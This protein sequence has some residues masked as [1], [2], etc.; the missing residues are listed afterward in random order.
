[1]SHVRTSPFYPQSNGKIES[2]HKTLKRECIRPHAPQSLDD[3]KRIVGDFVGDYNNRRL[4]SAI[5]YVTP[6]DRLAG[7][8]SEILKIRD[9]RIEQARA[10]RQRRRALGKAGNSTEQAQAG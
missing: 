2:W 9:E 3:A 4:H 5:C 8:D 10:D 7:R 1:M 6:A